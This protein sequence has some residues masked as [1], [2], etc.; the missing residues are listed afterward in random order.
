MLTDRSVR[1]GLAAALEVG[2]LG[3]VL[4]LHEEMEN[5]HLIASQEIEQ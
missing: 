5:A 1:H 2:N 3:D 4:A